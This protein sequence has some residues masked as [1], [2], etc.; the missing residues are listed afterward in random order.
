MVQG[1]DDND[2]ID[3]KNKRNGRK[4]KRKKRYVKITHRK[5][6]T[7]ESSLPAAEKVPDIGFMEKMILR[8][9]QLERQTARIH[10]DFTTLTEDVQLLVKEKDDLRAVVDKYKEENTRLKEQTS[11]MTELVGLL[12]EAE[13]NSIEN[14]KQKA[15]LG[16]ELRQI[17]IERDELRE[18]LNKV[19]EQDISAIEEHKKAENIAIEENKRLR[20]IIDD[21]QVQLELKEQDMKNM[22]EEFD[23]KIQ[24]TLQ[25][26]LS[27]QAKKLRGSPPKSKYDQMLKYSPN[28]NKMNKSM[29]NNN[30][31][32]IDEGEYIE[33]KLETTITVEEFEIVDTD[34]QNDNSANN[35]IIE[36]NTNAE[37][38]MKEDNNNSNDT[39][40]N[41]TLPITVEN[42]S[43]T[44]N[45][46]DNNNNNSYNTS[47]G[48]DVL[49]EIETKI[50]K[51]RRKTQQLEK[52]LFDMMQRQAMASIATSILSQSGFSMEEGSAILK[53]SSPEKNGGYFNTMLR[54]R[55]NNNR[56]QEK[57]VRNEQQ[58]EQIRQQQS[59]RQAPPPPPPQS[60]PITQQ[61]DLPPA[62]ILAEINSM[63]KNELI[64]AIAKYQ[65]MIDSIS[66]QENTRRRHT[67]KFASH[68][69]NHYLPI[70][71][72]NTTYNNISNKLSDMKNNSN[73]NAY[74]NDNYA[75]PRINSESNRSVTNSLNVSTISND[76][77]DLALR[78]VT[79]QTR[80]ESTLRQENKILREKVE[81]LHDNVVQFNVNPV[82]NTGGNANNTKQVVEDV[83]EDV[84]T[85]Q[86]E[87]LMPPP[88]PAYNETEDN[89]D[90][91]PPSYHED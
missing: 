64:G 14:N 73:N 37:K 56:Q 76:N 30:S 9:D 72:N 11:Q 39:Q 89:N 62:P 20:S 75:R 51:S 78:M 44:S 10:E 42:L 59:Q 15:H 53:S 36:D 85:F 48:I 61:A 46:N 19:R 79:Q 21:L 52:E 77:I 74:I 35:I 27:K 17:C 45:N 55:R 25:Q 66:H 23:I 87:D 28:S 83:V 1:E 4:K 26:A 34:Y 7:T 5:H 47:N 12:N 81:Q 54:T 65:V 58:Q 90:T 18:K 38:E 84:H 24:S 43:S 82:Y 91:P 50:N 41:E 6:Q 88:P 13:Q 67:A 3:K 29:N 71:K 86:D 31:N 57:E 32:R 2:P 68:A 60:A 63:S 49:D 80:N 16:K 22:K 69:S 33:N 70:K 8:N 40:A